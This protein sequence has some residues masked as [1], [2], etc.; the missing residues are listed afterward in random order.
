MTK[1]ILRLAECDLLECLIVGFS[2]CWQAWCQKKPSKEM[3]CRHCA[4]PTVLWKSCL[5]LLISF[6]WHTLLSYMLQA[7]FAPKN[8]NIIPFSDINSWKGGYSW[9]LIINLSVHLCIEFLVLVVFRKLLD[10]FKYP[11]VALWL[12]NL[13]DSWSGW[14]LILIWFV[15]VAGKDVVSKKNHIVAMLW[16]IRHFAWNMSSVNLTELHD[17]WCLQ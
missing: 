15:H 10:N 3:R 2:W 7:G 8:P 17:K 16:V 11:Q 12:D 14:K 5:Y 4:N 9:I 13:G 6:S 1:Y